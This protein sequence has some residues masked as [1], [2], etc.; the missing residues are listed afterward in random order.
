MTM[1]ELNPK[2][3]AIFDATNIDDNCD[4]IAGMINDEGTFVKEE[5]EAGAIEHA[6]TMYLQLLKS[7]T[8][9]FIVDEH[10]CYFDDMYSPEYVLQAIYNYIM[11]HD[12]S[13]DIHK[14]LDVGHSEIMDSECYQEYGYPSYI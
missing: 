2:Y 8:K 7:M 14:L 5:L 9:H 4:K 3:E 1:I 13:D 6:V 10:W 12:I 11:N